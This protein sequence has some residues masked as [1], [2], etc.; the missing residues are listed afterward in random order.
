MQNQF[1]KETINDVFNKYFQAHDELME[2]L[3]VFFN[4]REEQVTWVTTRQAADRTGEGIR[5]IQ[6]WATSNKVRTR[7]NGHTYEVVLE[8]VIKKHESRHKA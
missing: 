8:D 5:N 3:R 2:A 6:N 1:N 7:R 4:H